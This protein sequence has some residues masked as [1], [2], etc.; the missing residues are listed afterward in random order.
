MDNQIFR[1]KLS[2]ECNLEFHIARTN[3]VQPF[4]KFKELGVAVVKNNF[5]EDGHLDLE[6]IDSLIKYLQDCRDHVK[7]FNENSKPEPSSPTL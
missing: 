3:E 5:Q 2:T 7:Q 6:G 1:L 4:R